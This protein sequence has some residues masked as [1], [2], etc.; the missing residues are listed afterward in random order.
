MGLII[1]SLFFLCIIGI[2]VTIIFSS[3]YFVE[4]NYVRKTIADEQE[5]F[6]LEHGTLLL[7]QRNSDYVG[8]LSIADTELNNPFFQTDDNEFYLNHDSFKKETSHGALFM[9]YRSELSHKNIVIYGNT[10]DDDLLFST[11]HEYRGLNFF[12][13]HP[14]ITMTVAQQK[15]D[16]KIFA[17]FIMNSKAKQDDEEIYNVCQKDFSGKEVFYKWI[18]EAK[19]RS[20][21]STQP[22]LAMEDNFLTLITNCDDFNGARL[23]VMA[24]QLREGEKAKEYYGATVNQ[25]PKL[26]KIWYSKRNIK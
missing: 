6:K 23:V 11:L 15:T 10:K 13:T 7:K 24:R 17:V 4:Y 1:K 9:D 22:P 21:I 8:W 12:K 18:K 2:V 3:I 20:L 14:V 26:P 19:E 25:N 16:Y 5:I